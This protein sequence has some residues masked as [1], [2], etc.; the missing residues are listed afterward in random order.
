MSLN[1]EHDPQTGRFGVVVDG[2]TC[3]LEYELVGKTM[4]ITHTLVPSAVGGRG[5]AGDLVRTALE[6]A[7]ANGWKVIPACS[8]ADAFMKKH[9][10]YADLLA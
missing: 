6:T 10:E 3:V 1:I 5:I 7:R 4:T 9:R 8:Y 2:Q